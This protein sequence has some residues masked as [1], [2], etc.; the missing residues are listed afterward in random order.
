VSEQLRVT[1]G[2]VERVDAEDDEGV[3]IRVAAGGR[4]F[5][6]AATRDVTRAGL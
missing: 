3:G 2:L 1:N 5:G 6:F 4:G